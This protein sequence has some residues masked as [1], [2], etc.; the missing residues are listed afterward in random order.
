MSQIQIQA[1]LFFFNCCKIWETQPLGERVSLE[2]ILRT[3]GVTNADIR[4]KY[5]TNF[6]FAAKS[7]GQ[8]LSLQYLSA[9]L[10]LLTVACSTQSS[11]VSELFREQDF[12]QPFIDSLLRQ[13]VINV[14]LQADRKNENNPALKQLAVDLQSKVIILLSEM[15]NNRLNEGFFRKLADGDEYAR[16]FDLIVKQMIE[17]ANKL[18]IIEFSGELPLNRIERETVD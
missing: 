18:P 4:Q 15:A 14:V 13:S 5:I 1:I 11:F 6:K 7:L 8:S 10:D 17:E 16:L 2:S 9:F 12:S 3:T